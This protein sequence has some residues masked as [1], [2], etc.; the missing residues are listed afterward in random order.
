[1]RFEDDDAST[2][3]Q[4]RIKNAARVFHSGGKH[5]NIAPGRTFLK[6]ATVERT[7]V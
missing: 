6:I 2:T 7:N 4:Y 5:T 3:F 1:M